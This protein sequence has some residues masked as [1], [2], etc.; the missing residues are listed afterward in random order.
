[1]KI[2]SIAV[3]DSDEVLLIEPGAMVFGASFGITAD[4]LFIS[5]GNQQF[6][7]RLKEILEQIDP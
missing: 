6:R 2:I 3:H 5:V 1:M 4:S 7:I